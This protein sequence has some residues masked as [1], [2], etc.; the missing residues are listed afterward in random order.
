M[1]IVLNN[2]VCFPPQLLCF[3]KLPLVAHPSMRIFQITPVIPIRML[4]LVTMFCV[5]VLSL[6]GQVCS[7]IRPPLGY[8]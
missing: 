3:F 8:I 1:R 6:I 5:G 4:W 2:W 7:S